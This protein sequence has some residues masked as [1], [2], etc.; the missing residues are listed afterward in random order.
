MSMRTRLSC[1]VLLVKYK[2]TLY[3]GPKNN[4]IQREVP[5]SDGPQEYN[6]VN[7]KLK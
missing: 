6:E 4:N 2:K 1:V 7:F 3:K 5:F